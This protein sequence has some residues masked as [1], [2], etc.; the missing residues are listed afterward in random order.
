MVYGKFKR[1]F[2]SFLKSRPNEKFNPVFTHMCLKT[3]CKHSKRWIGWFWCLVFSKKRFVQNYPTISKFTPIQN[4]PTL[5]YYIVDWGGFGH[6]VNSDGIRNVG[7]IWIKAIPFRE[8]SCLH[9]SPENSAIN[10]L[11]FTLKLLIFEADSPSWFFCFLAHMLFW[12][13]T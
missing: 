11:N 3:S 12:G 4:Y 13:P 6:G 2:S 8:Q 7:A 5:P 1:P 9:K 10:K